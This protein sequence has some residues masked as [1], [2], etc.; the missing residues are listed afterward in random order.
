[1]MGWMAPLRHRG[2]KLVFL[3]NHQ[4][5]VQPLCVQQHMQSLPHV[6]Y[7]YCFRFLFSVC[8]VILLARRYAAS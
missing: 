1:M 2:A 3:E 6:L 5:P 8:D 7:P 4:Q